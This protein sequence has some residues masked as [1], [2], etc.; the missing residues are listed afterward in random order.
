[1][2]QPRSSPKTAGSMTTTS[3]MVV[4]VNF[5]GSPDLVLQHLAQVLAITVLEHGLCELFNLLG[6]NPARAVGDLSMQA[7]FRPWR[8]SSVAMNWLA[9]SRLSCVPVSSQA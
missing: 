3:R 8:F 9:S 4:G 1:M 2:N 5:M 6:A 7:T